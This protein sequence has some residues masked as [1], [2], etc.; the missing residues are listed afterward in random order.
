MPARLQE[1]RKLLKFVQ[2]FPA[3]AAWLAHKAVVRRPWFKGSVA[4][5]TSHNTVLLRT[6]NHYAVRAR[7]VNPYNGLR[8]QTLNPPPIK[9][10]PNDVIF[11]IRGGGGGAFWNKLRASFPLNLGG[12]HRGYPSHV[13][14]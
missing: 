5:S 2:R 10:L 12:H 7:F 6:M 14:P 1:W 3:E 8:G 11:W 13:T 4:I 9:P